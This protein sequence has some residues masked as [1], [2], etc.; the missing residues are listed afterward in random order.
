ME[1]IPVWEVVLNRK[2]QE[3]HQQ[4]LNAGRGIVPVAV[5]IG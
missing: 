3:A 5:E 4:W 2:A 1:D